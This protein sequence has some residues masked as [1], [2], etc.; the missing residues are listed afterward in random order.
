MNEDYQLPKHLS[1]SQVQTYLACGI[2]YYYQYLLRVRR[3]TSYYMT[4]GSA[5]DA[6]FNANYAPKIETGKDEP[7]DVL[8]DVFH[9]DFK[10]RKPETDFVELGM[11]G[12]IKAKIDPDTIENDGIE[13]VKHFR[14]VVAP[15]VQ[16]I[17][18]Q[19][20]LEVPFDNVD[21]SFLGFTDLTVALDDNGDRKMIID[22]KTTARKPPDGTVERNPQLTAY[23][24]LYHACEGQIPAVGLSHFIRPQKTNP[25]RHLHTISTRSEQDIRNWWVIVGQV[26]H[27]IKS[28]VFLPPQLNTFGRPTDQCNRR[29]CGYYD[30]CRDEFF[31][32]KI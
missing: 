11:D 3:A 14:D 24:A 21:Y 20:R 6:A 27:G 28:G 15:T 22:H 4:L 2:R 9:E 25:A 10:A 12:S 7:L 17:A 26:W 5:A 1:Y 31:N 23:A 32:Q 19:S 30:R 18:V 16:P 29:W 8:I 13:I